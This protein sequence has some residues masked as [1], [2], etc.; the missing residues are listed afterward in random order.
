MKKTF[1][2]LSTIL[3]CACSKKIYVFPHFYK[4]EK[5]NEIIFIF[6]NCNFGE[7]YNLTV[8]NKTTKTVYYLQSTDLINYHSFNSKDSC[9][10]YIN[11]QSLN[12]KFN[13]PKKSI[14][15]K[16]IKLHRIE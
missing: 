16:L 8:A 10:I 6:E 7:K 5:N 9:K 2:I 14:S 15:C 13:S 11:S 4:V 3:I 12:Y 1:L